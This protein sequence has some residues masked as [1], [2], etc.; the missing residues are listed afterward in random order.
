MHGQVATRPVGGDWTWLE[1]GFAGLAKRHNPLLGQLLS[2]GK[3]RL[4]A[5]S[6]AVDCV[7]IR[8]ASLVGAALALNRSICIGLPDANPR[9]PAFI[10]AY[11]LLSYWWKTRELKSER[12]PVLY[13]GVETG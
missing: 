5:A 3:L 4:A 8:S 11:A 13:C 2:P 10:F 9:R 6:G 1:H 7:D 12:R